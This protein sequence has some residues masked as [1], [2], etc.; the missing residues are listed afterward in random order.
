M[1]DTPPDAL[2]F[3]APGCPHCSG[4]LQGLTDL[5]KR[6]D[7]GVL[8]VIN[9]AVCPERAASLGIRSAPW[10]RIGP[11]ILEGAQNPA[12]LERWAAHAAH[13]SGATDYLHDLLG[14]G[15][16]SHATAW[17]GNDPARLAELLPLLA[18]PESPMQVRLGA[19]ALLEGLAGSEALISLTAQLGELSHHGD[20]RVRGDAS[21]LLGLTGSPDAL[22]YLK[23]RLSDQSLEVREIAAESIDRLSSH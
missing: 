5:V 19:T 3:I 23:E 7:V 17:V 20:H 10:C 6:G 22:P 1:A 4:V 11:F 21:H 15:R 14:S 16:L 2:L 8:E 9:A 13:G 18:D 12:S